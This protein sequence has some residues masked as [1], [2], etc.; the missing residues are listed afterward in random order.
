MAPLLEAIHNL[1]VDEVVIAASQTI[2]VGQVLGAVGVAADETLTVTAK[3]GN[4][5][6]GAVTPDA[7]APVRSDAIDG[8]YQIE[9]LSTGATAAFNV[10]DPTGVLVGEGAVGAG[11]AGPIKFAIADDSS[12]HY[13][14]G[15]VLY[16]QVARP[17]GEAA[18]QFEAWSPTATNGS[19][20]AVAVAMYPA[21]TGAGQT[22]K[23]AA[24][25]RDAVVRASD[26]TW[27]SSA[28]ANQ[29]AEATNQ[30]A[31]AK[32]ILR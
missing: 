29:I 16:M 22:A 11:F 5:G 4:V 15:D 6:D 30:L 10:L 7:T 12:H 3:A 9:F 14:L 19:Q 28:T 18:E 17:F 8:Q 31:R 13:T 27:N 23:I 26:L 32:I 24:V 21:T 1:S 20:T 25:R 2:V